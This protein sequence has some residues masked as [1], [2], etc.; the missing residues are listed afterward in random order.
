MDKTAESLHSQFAVH[1]NPK[2]RS[3]VP[4][5]ELLLDGP[6][7]GDLFVQSGPAFLHN[8]LVPRLM[9]KPTGAVLDIGCGMGAHARA[10]SEF[11]TPIGKYCGLDVTARAIQ[12][13]KENY[14]E[15][16][17]FQFDWANVRSDWYNPQSSIEP[18]HYRF[19]YLEDTFDVTF[20]ISLFTHIQ[21]P[22][23]RNYLAEVCRILKPGG[24]LWLTCFLMPDH[25]SVRHASCVQG[26]EFTRASPLHHVIDPESP[27]RGVAYDER[28]LRRML[29]EAG[30]VLAE[31]AFGRWASE[32]DVLGLYQDAILGV[33]PL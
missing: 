30:L 24:R 3:L 17:N 14:V 6:E 11:L 10:L 16:K 27:S 31:S 15:F 18:E 26:R 22:A 4:P 28:G 25:E 19:P 23:A 29:S 5:P 2:M 12:W 21:P 8:V 7:S 33:K 20:A 13:C 1:M 9:L 32:I